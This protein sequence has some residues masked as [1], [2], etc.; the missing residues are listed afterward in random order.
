MACTTRKD[1]VVPELLEEAIT[2]EITTNPILFGT[3]AVITRNTLGQVKGGDVITVPVWGSLGEFQDVDEG[4]ALTPRKLVQSTEKSEVQR[5]G[6]AWEITDWAQMAAAG[7]P[8]A[9]AARQVRAAWQRR[10]DAAIM[11]KALTTPLIYNGTA[12]KLTWQAIVAAKLL[13]GDEADRLALLAVHSKVAADLMLQSDTQGRP[14]LVDSLIDG[15]LPTML[16]LP[17]K[18]T[19]RLP[20]DTT[21]D[22][23]IYTSIIARENSLVFW[24]S[25][26]PEIETDRDILAA[27]T[28]AAVNMYFVAHLYSRVPGSTRPGV[29]R[30]NH[31]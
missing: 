2:N 21:P 11:A 9:E 10:A 6:L 19:D 20:V 18:I 31:Q 23:D 17:T 15:K 3:P 29:I 22:P 14:Y 5:S 12:A 1:V 16:G 30:I 26:E 7:D 8:Y 13:W 28:V 27:T 4:Q 24:S 25:G